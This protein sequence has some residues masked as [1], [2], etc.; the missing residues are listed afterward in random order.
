VTRDRCATLSKSLDHLAELDQ[1]HRV[2][3]V[4]NASTDDTRLM[5]SRRH[6]QVVLLPLDHNLGSAARTIG[7][8]ALGEPYVALCDDD[9]W[10][11]PG[12]LARAERVLDGHPA[13][14]LIAGRVLVG[15]AEREDP[16][17]CLMSR[18]PL[19]RHPGQAGA[20][21]LGFL[22]CAAVFRRSAYLGVGGFHPNFGVGGEETLLSVDLVSRGWELAYVPEVVAHH[23]PPPR[24]DSAGRRRRLARNSLW[25]TWLRRPLPGA[26]RHTA[27]LA[28]SA[29]SDPAVARGLADA[30][31]G[32]R[33]VF[34]ERRPVG[35]EVERG[36][37][38]L[39]DSI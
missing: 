12:S 21:V 1:G 4:D 11:A 15:D 30:V 33:W 27:R 31:A 39:E 23:H 13:L 29:L 5:V 19:P 8:A 3:V 25:L 35:H 2:V 28:H 10:W 34:R 18:S 16:T 14:G 36:L 32:G 20:P 37:R 22:A 6:P 7:A 9:S 24:P 38:A 26:L 17:C